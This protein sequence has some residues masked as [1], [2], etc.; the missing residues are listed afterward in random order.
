MRPPFCFLIVSNMR[1]L[2]R[3][4]IIISA[5]PVWYVIPCISLGAAIMES[6]V[7]L[8]SWLSFRHALWEPIVREDVSLHHCMLAATYYFIVTLFLDLDTWLEES[9]GYANIQRVSMKGKGR[10]MGET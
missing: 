6:A 3:L 1:R 9:V 10:R 7:E 4:G 8:L 5:K 2:S